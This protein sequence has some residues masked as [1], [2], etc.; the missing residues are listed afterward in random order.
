M[1]IIYYLAG[2]IEKATVQFREAFSIDAKDEVVRRYLAR[3]AIRHTAQALPAF[4][5]YI[6][7]PRRGGWWSLRWGSKEPHRF[8]G[9][10]TSSTGFSA[11]REYAAESN[12]KYQSFNEMIAFDTEVRLL[13]IDGL[14]FKI[15]NNSSVRLDLRI[16]GVQDGKRVLIGAAGESPKEVPFVLHELIE[17]GR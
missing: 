9:T 17:P 10:I 6:I 12:D 1:G 11:I 13:D 14:D 16:D 5:G 4:K 3:L 2:E 7:W 15:S 8:H